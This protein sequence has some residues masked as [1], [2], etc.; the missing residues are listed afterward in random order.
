MDRKA[1]VLLVD[2][3]MVF[4]TALAGVV[5]GR[6]DK[7]QAE[8]PGTE[9]IVTLTSGDEI[10]AM[11]QEVGTDELVVAVDGSQRALPKP[12]I[13]KITTA[14]RRTG[15]LWNGPLIGAAICGTIA[16]IGVAA[17]PDRDSDMWGFVPIWAGIGAG[18]GLGIDAAVQSRITLYKAPGVE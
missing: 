7:V 10:R 2:G 11:Y 15:P 5:P 16:A 14:E 3:L 18:I 12:G 13:A 1:L 6:W 9:M 4:A 17:Y 8:K